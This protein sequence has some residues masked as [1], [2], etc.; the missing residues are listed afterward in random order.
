MGVMERFAAILF[1]AVAFAVGSAQA[2]RPALEREAAPAAER[3]VGAY[4]GVASNSNNPP[5]VNV[6]AGATPPQVTWP[7]FEL[8]AQGRSRIF[9]QLTSR[10][11]TEVQSGLNQVVMVLKRAQIAGRN[12][13]RPLETRFFNT[14]VTRAYLKKRGTD[15]VLILELRSNALPVVGTEQAS[16]GY[17]FVFLDFPAGQY[18]Q[19]AREAATTPSSVS[20]DNAAI[21]KNQDSTSTS[22]SI[23]GKVTTPAIQKALSEQALRAIENEKPPILQP[24]AR[25]SIQLGK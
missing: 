21:E 20:G 22:L 18:I 15:T 17:F 8:L 16:S 4:E 19:P 25:G 23:S 6:P 9:V 1:F 11:E 3:R 13:R 10:V 12:N 24:K 7:G 14:P 5:A 2:Q